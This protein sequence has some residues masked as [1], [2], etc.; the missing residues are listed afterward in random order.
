MIVTVSMNLQWKRFEVWVILS[1]L[2]KGVK[3]KSLLTTEN[4]VLF[5]EFIISEFTI[6]RLNDV[7]K[8]KNQTSEFTILGK[9]NYKGLDF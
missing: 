2:R 7:R 4:T 5:A 3:C 9:N 8:E 6:N 1:K